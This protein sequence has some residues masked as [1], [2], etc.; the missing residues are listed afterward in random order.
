MTAVMTTGDARSKSQ[1]G[2]GRRHEPVPAPGRPFRVTPCP[3]IPR[4][5]QLTGTWTA[6]KHDFSAVLRWR[7]FDGTHN[8]RGIS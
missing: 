7:K 3:V 5:V 1:L 4:A 2:A 8:K 6:V